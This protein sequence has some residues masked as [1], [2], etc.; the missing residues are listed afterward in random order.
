ME[1][2][3]DM[4]ALAEKCRAKGGAG[5]EQLVKANWEAIKEWLMESAMLSENKMDDMAVPLALPIIDKLLA[6]VLDQ[7]DGKAG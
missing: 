7:I 6:P 2:A 1:K 5:A 4:K 3:Y